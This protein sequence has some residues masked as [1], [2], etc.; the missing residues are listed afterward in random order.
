MNLKKRV[1]QLGE[2]PSRVHVVG[3]LG[4]EHLHHRVPC[5]LFDQLQCRLVRSNKAFYSI[6][7]SS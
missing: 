3:E 1:I 2:Q 6:Y 7:L 5:S 4:L